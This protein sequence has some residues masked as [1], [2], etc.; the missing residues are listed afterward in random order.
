[1][2]KKE[3]NQRMNVDFIFTL[4]RLGDRVRDL[5]EE[6]NELSVSLDRFKEDCLKSLSTQKSEK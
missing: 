6:I 4:S 3:F 5:S 2:N 1:M